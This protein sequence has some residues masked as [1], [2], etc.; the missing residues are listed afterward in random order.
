[1]IP[2]IRTTNWTHLSLHLPIILYVPCHRNPTLLALAFVSL[3]IASV[4]CILHLTSC[5]I[6]PAKFQS[7]NTNSSTIIY[8]IS[9]NWITLRLQ[10]P[11]FTARR[12]VRCLMLFSYHRLQY[13][14]CNYCW[15]VY[16]IIKQF[17]CLF[18][19]QRRITITDRP[20]FETTSFQIFY[21]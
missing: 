1:M 19:Y 2:K 5:L 17:V 14:D 4:W 9:S 6:L 3:L 11:L 16:I 13:L 18:V 7:A 8:I 20:T 15:N 21:Y 12:A 10:H